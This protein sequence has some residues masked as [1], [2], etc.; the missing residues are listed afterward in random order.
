MIIYFCKTNNIVYII[1][2]ILLNFFF[3]LCV[4]ETV[5]S[6]IFGGARLVCHEGPR[7]MKFIFTGNYIVNGN[8]GGYP[9]KFGNK[10]KAQAELFDICLNGDG[11][12]SKYF[13]SE[14]TLKTF[15]PEIETLKGKTNDLFTKIKDTVDKSNILTTPLNNLEN[16]V[17]I[18]SILELEEMK[19]NLFIASNNF[20]GDDIQVLLNNIKTNL[21]DS[22]CGKTNENF[23]IK[24]SDCPSNSILSSTI[25]SDDGIHCYIIQKLVKGEKVNY[26]GTKCQND[27]TNKV[28]SFIQEVDLILDARIQKVKSLQ[29][30]YSNTWRNMYHEI[31]ELND[32]VNNIFSIINN[33]ISNEIKLKTNCSS[34][35]FDLINFSDYF[36]QKMEYKA[37]II[38]IFAAFC[39]TFGWALLYFFMIVIN[40]QTEGN[41]EESEYEEFGYQYKTNDKKKIEGNSRRKINTYD[42]DDKEDEEE[43]DDYKSAPKKSKKKINPPKK[44]Q[45]VEMSYLNKSEESDS[46]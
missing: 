40:S 11:D 17:F 28:I 35:R 31:S 20:G 19:N 13:F 14:N 7:I 25:L 44:T 38:V 12:L 45:K 3:I 22:L 5:L 42:K 15:L 23:V 2:V 43:D 27:Y 34:T 39:G 36:S 29:E 6:A 9:A 32:K 37:R 30:N 33:G 10:D 4:Y 18:T 8:G 24:Q 26:S 1:L 41:E 16:S 46:D 21:A